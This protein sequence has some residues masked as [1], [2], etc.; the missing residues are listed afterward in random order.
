MRPSDRRY[1]WKGARYTLR[2]EWLYAAVGLAARREGCTPGVRDAEHDGWSVDDFVRVVNAH[3]HKQR[4][5]IAREDRG[6][7]LGFD[8]RHAYL[9]RNEVIAVR[10]YTGP[11]YQV[12]AIR[13]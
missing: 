11:V 3:V 5:R 9:D 10:L 2:N 6:R 13:S 7:T 12:S 8:E 4:A 1:D